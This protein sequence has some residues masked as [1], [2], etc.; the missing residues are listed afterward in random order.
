MILKR[1]N[2][3]YD[4]I[5]SAEGRLSH[6]HGQ[7]RHALAA[8]LQR[9]RYSMMCA[10]IGRNILER[11]YGHSQAIAI[12]HDVAIAGSHE[13]ID[14]LMIDAQSGEVHVISTQHLGSV[15]V[16]ELGNKWHADYG[17]DRYEIEDPRQRLRRQ[18]TMVQAVVGPERN[19][20][21]IALLPPDVRC[22]DHDN[23]WIF[24]LPSDRFESFMNKRRG[25]ND[26]DRLP[27]LSHDE[28]LRVSGLFIDCAKALAEAMPDNAIEYLNTI[29][30][31]IR[32]K[33]LPN[34]HYALRNQSNPALIEAVRGLVRGQG[35]W[36]PK[37]HNWVVPPE[38][39]EKVRQHFAGD[40]KK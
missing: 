20:T 40:N 30:G 4:D 25:G 38:I 37:Y 39:M 7:A 34:G 31:A 12:L 28:L 16:Q 29:H 8:S 21:G 14:H 19:V 26:P 17:R 11:A 15:I 13:C 1:A 9:Q 3:R 22:D 6:L 36:N 23:R 5:K 2:D 32:I 18:M 10:E 35:W 24:L 33:R 27:R